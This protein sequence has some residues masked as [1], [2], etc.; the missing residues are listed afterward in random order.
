MMELVLRPETSPSIEKLMIV[1]P[2]LK[3]RGE[4]KVPLR[5]LYKPFA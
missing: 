4:A 5:E 1:F 2:E 3:K